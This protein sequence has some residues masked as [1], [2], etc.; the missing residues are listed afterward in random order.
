MKTLTAFFPTLLLA[1]AATT[2][3][4]HPDQDFQYSATCAAKNPAV[5]SAIAA[6]CSK[7]DGAGRYSDTIMCPGPRS[8][9]G[10]VKD[11]V[12]AKITGNCAP[13]QWI[14][15][16]FCLLQ[17]HYICATGDAN[18]LGT[19]TYGTNACQKWTLESA[20]PNV[21]GVLGAFGIGKRGWAEEGERDLG[22]ENE[23]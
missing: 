2:T 22:L 15:G 9:R 10:I 20:T 6:F 13:Q 16:K 11:G 4:Q 19:G 21:P 1:L 3:A 17:F 5:N 18:G 12:R 23:K 14:P 7:K 8:E